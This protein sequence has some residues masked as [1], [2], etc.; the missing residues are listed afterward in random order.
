ML[1][2]PSGLL[3]KPNSPEKNNANDLLRRLNHLAWSFRAAKIDKLSE[4]C[5][6]ILHFC[7]KNMYL[8]QPFGERAEPQMEHHGSHRESDDE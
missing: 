5:K 4:L 3:S 1:T 8:V 7:H 2:K 6:H